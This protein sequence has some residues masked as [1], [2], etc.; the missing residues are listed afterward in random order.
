MHIKK[1][2][3]DTYSII[4]TRKCTYEFRKFDEAIRMYDSSL[5]LNPNLAKTYTNKGKA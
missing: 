5:K 3:R 1:K 4:I 2:V